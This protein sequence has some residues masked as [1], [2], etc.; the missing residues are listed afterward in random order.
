MS[1]WELPTSTNIGGHTYTF[2]S[3]F[4]AV[5][6]IIAAMVDP[7]LPSQDRAVVCLLIFYDEFEAMNRRDWQEAIDYMQWFI[8]GGDDKPPKKQAKLMDWVQDADL[9]AAPVN[10]VLG[11]ECRTCDYLHWWSFLAA[12]MEIGDCLFAQVVSIR[13]KLRSGKKLD[14]SDKQFYAR[15]KHLVDFKIE[16]TE[17]E[18]EI[19]NEWIG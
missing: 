16:P 15:N 3:D 8:N 19:V 9:I 14:K 5:L 10:R 17:Q 18:N 13:K 7:E 11:Y 4:R 12:Y 2:R 1:K 6:D